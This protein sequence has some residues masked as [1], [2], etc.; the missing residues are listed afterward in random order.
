[1]SD[2]VCLAS[3]ESDFSFNSI[4]LN[5]LKQK[6]CTFFSKKI[7]SIVTENVYALVVMLPIGAR[8][9]H[10]QARQIIKIDR[11]IPVSTPL[12]FHLTVPLIVN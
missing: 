5:L 1:M 2:F 6:N 9:G 4:R 10:L 11:L 12:R 7:D 8:K 3:V